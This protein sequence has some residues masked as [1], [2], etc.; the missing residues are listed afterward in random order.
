MPVA[1]LVM[2]GEVICPPP[3][4]A[5]ADVD[6]MLLSTTMT[7]TTTMDAI[8]PGTADLDFPGV[9]GYGF[10]GGVNSGCM[11]SLQVPPASPIPVPMSFVDLP[12]G[13]TGICTALSGSGSFEYLACATGLATGSA[14]FTEPADSTAT[15]IDN[16]TIAFFSGVGV[17]SAAPPLGGY[18]D[19]GITG[20]V[21]GPALMTM[22]SGTSC[23][24]GDDSFGLVMALVAAYGT[25]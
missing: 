6:V 4:L 19:D 15:H 17:L 3:A 1:G 5:A 9:I 16:Y 12:S 10:S 7:F 20:A 8:P 2:L 25:T 14:Q 21:S 11:T 23:V 22:R 13:T 18:V 24:F